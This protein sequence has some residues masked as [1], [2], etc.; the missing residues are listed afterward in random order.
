MR[1]FFLEYRNDN[2]T[3]LVKATATAKEKCIHPFFHYQMFYRFSYFLFQF[4]PLFRIP[5]SKKTTTFH[6]FP[7]KQK[8]ACQKQNCFQRL[9]TRQIFSLIKKM[10]PHTRR[11]H[12]IYPLVSCDTLFF[13]QLLPLEMDFCK[14]RLDIILPVL[15]P[16][17]NYSIVVVKKFLL[18]TKNRNVASLLYAFSLFLS[19]HF[20]KK[21]Q[22]FLNR[23]F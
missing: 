19:I 14:T 1:I 18:Y 7:Y 3:Q 22:Y 21:Y 16:F 12:S 2:M 6:K 17:R 15:Y 8:R 4:F 20:I 11:H 23:Q 13:V 5:V 10:S 9:F